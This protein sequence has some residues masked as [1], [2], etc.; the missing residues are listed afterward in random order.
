MHLDILI[1]MKLLLCSVTSPGI[2]FLINR[3]LLLCSAISPRIALA[4]LAKQSADFAF[5]IY[6][7]LLLCGVT[8]PR[9]ALAIL[10][11]QSAGFA[12]LYRFFYIVIAMEAAAV[13]LFLPLLFL[14]V[15][16]SGLPKKYMVWLW[17]L[18]FLR[19]VCP[20]QISS[21]FS[22]VPPWNR[23]YH[24]FLAD[25]GL[26]IDAQHG[27][28]LRSLSDV[29][30]ANI[31]VTSLYRIMAIG[32]FA[33]MLLL[34]V[35]L[36]IRAGKVR[37]AI[38]MREKRLE[39][40][41][42][43]SA[44]ELPVMTG[45]F[46]NRVFLPETMNVQEAKYTLAH[47]E[48]RRARRSNL[49]NAFYVT[50]LLLHWYDPCVWAAV[51]LVRRDEQMAC[52]ECAVDRCSA[53]DKNAYIQGI[54]NIVPQEKRV[55][56]TACASF[57]TDLERRSQRLLHQGSDRMCYKMIGVILLLLMFF[58]LFLLRP[59]Q[60]VWAGGTWNAGSEKL[61]ANKDTRKTNLIISQ[62]DV[63]SPS[64]LK[65]TVSLRHK[66][67]E[68]NGRILAN[69]YELQ[70]ADAAGSELAVVDLQKVFREQGI[71][72]DTLYF[73]EGLK[74]QT[75]D[76]NNDG[77]QELLLGQQRAW[78][79]TEQKQIGRLLSNKT[80]SKS[81]TASSMGNENV[82]PTPAKQV[83]NL[84]TYVYVM[85]QMQET[86]LQI[87]SE[88]VY[89]EQAASMQ[90][91]KPSQESDVKDLFYMQLSDGKLYYIWDSDATKF[92]AKKLSSDELN[93]HRRASQGTEEAGVSKTETLEDADGNECMRVQTTTD[94]TGS[95]EIGQI[96]MSQNKKKMNE[97]KGYFCELKWVPQSD[98]SSGRYAVLIYNGT[99]AQTFVLYDVDKA[100]ELYRQEDGN[101]ILSSIFAKYN[102]TQ[103]QFK[104]GAIAV[105]KLAEQ[106]GSRLT[107]DFAA[108]AEDGVDV[109]GSYV[110][111]MDSEQISNLQYNQSN[112][113]TQTKNSST[114]NAGTDSDSSS[115]NKGTDSSSKRKNTTTS[116][117]VPTINSNLGDYL[118]P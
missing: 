61:S 50:A 5:S 79:A 23:S 47:M 112:D 57:E 29:W 101:D 34:V 89:G 107:I 45:L 68:A 20:I 115:S 6:R 111:D 66:R 38:R 1:D 88:A 71:A 9:I 3:K 15:V 70:L 63:L 30:Q 104:S 97:V 49:W 52:D 2:A 105:Y 118:D 35:L 83:K 85:F 32:Y 60:N 59:V 76:Y 82:T 92:L 113:D 33:G 65:Q 25:V 98:A 75:G 39:G 58:W 27:G 28:L 22:I 10:A 16:I 42:Y 81:K 72:K 46:V 55:P 19:I 51:F 40:T 62:T 13:S 86:G 7:K 90:S 44:V 99:K 48:C 4:I 67:N 116:Q 54:L 17:R 96:M 36:V 21:T 87:V 117:P 74:L 73:P 108:E 80:D 103:I 12:F 110:Y 94:T 41:L 24:R 14:R 18:Y 69:S 91:V 64:G 95:P 106:N 43:Q 37:S 53:A 78:D 26:D 11:K 102:D 100:T 31:Q 8:S 77:I 84:R 114:G 109:S 93:Q 56:F